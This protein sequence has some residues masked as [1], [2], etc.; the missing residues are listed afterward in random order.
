M[1][2]LRALYLLNKTSNGPYTA[3][4]WSS[5]SNDH[6]CRVDSFSQHYMMIINNPVLLL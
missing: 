2:L 4:W 5:D 1:V 6:L 3:Y